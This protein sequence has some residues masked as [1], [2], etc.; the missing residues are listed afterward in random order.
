MQHDA[1]GEPPVPRPMLRLKTRPVGYL[2]GF[3]RVAWITSLLAAPAYTQSD[4]FIK[5]CR[6]WIDKKG[7]ST[8]YIEEKLGKRQAGMA[9][10]WRG[11]V[12]V[13]DV[14]AGDVVFGIDCSRFG[15]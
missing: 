3:I 9:S 1:Q 8:D 4:N 12:A 15:K 6:Q 7:Y 11:N 14:Q 5:E 10:S 2:A 13:A